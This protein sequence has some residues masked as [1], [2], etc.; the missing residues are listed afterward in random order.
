M[1]SLGSMNNETSR[2]PMPPCCSYIH[3][4]IMSYYI[5]RCLLM[6]PVIVVEVDLRVELLS[7]KNLGENDPT[8]KIDAGSASSN[9]RSQRRGP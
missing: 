8:Y 7:F 4:M 2:Y 5:T 6:L 1:M 9:P 3:I